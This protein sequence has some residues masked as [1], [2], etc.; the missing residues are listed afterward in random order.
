M[1]R[2]INLIKI[3]LIFILIISFILNVFTQNRIEITNEFSAKGSVFVETK[4]VLSNDTL[5]KSGAYLLIEKRKK[6]YD[7]V[8]TINKI[9]SE[10]SL[11]YYTLMAKGDYQNNEKVDEWMENFGLGFYRNGIYEKGK[12][13]GE[14]K[15]YRINH[16]CGRGNYMDDKKVSDWFY[17]DKRY[18]SK[19]TL[20]LHYNYDKDSIMAKFDGKFEKSKNFNFGALHFNALDTNQH[21]KLQ[22]IFPYGGNEGFINVFRDNF[23]SEESYMPGSIGGYYQIYIR[24][25]IDAL[26]LIDYKIARLTSDKTYDSDEGF[27]QKMYERQISIMPIEWIPSRPKKACATIYYTYLRR[28]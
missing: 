27:V 11:F 26:G 9:I 24:I 4:H 12:K 22:P 18:Y 21:I 13:I 10:D 2:Q 15:E 6:W 16:L 8:K 25:K 5:I 23:Y 20:F 14:W 28:E 3:S 1:K 17:Y 7:K 19:D